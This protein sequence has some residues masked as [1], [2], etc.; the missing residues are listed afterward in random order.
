M[1]KQHSRSNQVWLK[2]SIVIPLSTFLKCTNTR[3]A[4]H[5]CLMRYDCKKSFIW[6]RQHEISPK[7]ELS[8]IVLPFWY[9]FL[10]TSVFINLKN[11][12]A[13]SSSQAFFHR[14]PALHFSW[15]FSLSSPCLWC[16]CSVFFNLETQTFFLLQI[17]FSFLLFFNM[18]DLE[19]NPWPINYTAKT[20][21]VSPKRKSAVFLKPTD[22]RLI[23]KVLC[24]T[25]IV[26]FKMTTCSLML[27][28]TTDKHWQRML[29]STGT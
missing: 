12:H 25:L 13:T 2:H 8:H 24:L 1:G 9:P 15:N 20:I 23:F 17:Y 6:T 19:K 4:F 7:W 3:T 14:E 28:D 22:N 27:S 11:T 10:N 5:W 16:L 21:F 26:C 18:Q 29:H